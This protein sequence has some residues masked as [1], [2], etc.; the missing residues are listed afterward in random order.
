MKKLKGPSVN[1][2]LLSGFVLI[3]AL[4]A[5]VIITA[6]TGLA[7]MERLEGDLYTEHFENM[8]NLSAMRS[9]LNAERLDVAVILA[10]PKSRWGPWRTNL[11]SR[12][13]EDS[14]ALSRLTAAFATNEAQRGRLQR[15]TGLLDK[16]T[17]TQ[18]TRVLP[19]LISGKSA[20][21]EELF[22][23][24]QLERH[25]EMSAILA[26]M[27]RAERATAIGRVAETKNKV[28]RRVGLFVLFGVLL[29]LVVIGLGV[30]MRR[31]VS[32]Q[33]A[34]RRTAEDA[35][36]DSEQKYRDLVEDMSEGIAVANADGILA[37]VNPRIAEMLEYSPEEMLGKQVAAFVSGES[38]DL[39]KSETEKRRMGIPGK[40]EVI[41]AS[42]TG[43]RVPL[44]VSGKPL[45]KN[46]KYAGSL[47]VFVDITERKE[48]EKE[49]LESE[50][51][52]RSLFEGIGDSVLVYN[53][54][55]R[56]VDCNE[57]ALKQYG[58][59][60]HEF[61]KLTLADIVHGDF[62]QLAKMNQE[63]LWAGGVVVVESVHMRR[64]GE[65]FPV[66]VHAR[67]IAYQGE[68]AILGVVRDI[69]ERKRAED[70]IRQSEEKWR[71]LVQT[72]PDFVALY[73]SQG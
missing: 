39:L 60:R 22:R 32:Q 64:N 7:D 72:I 2:I 31:T 11:D 26:E 10:T 14:L 19:S 54:D 42:K 15:L 23:G 3:I 12:M 27:N 38:A 65:V 68:P 24:I 51:R 45:F 50:S 37:Y 58:R 41:F 53:L 21:A 30:F 56:L 69:T 73:D 28:W 8:S 29:G 57:A 48:A 9:N 52:Y 40:F 43:N 63:K 55:G 6:Y 33:L 13:K 62:L 18:D 70:T 61:L 4:F 20:K 59:S 47:G 66:E 67:N 36:V 49:L 17:E 44:I 5:V 46:G 71:L 35:L 25:L 16:F 34:N 1:A